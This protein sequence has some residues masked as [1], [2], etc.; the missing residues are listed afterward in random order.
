MADIPSS[1]GTVPAA[2]DIP[3]TTPATT[4][5]AAPSA[6]PAESRR[7]LALHLLWSFL[8][9]VALL[10]MIIAAALIIWQDNVGSIDQEGRNALLS[11]DSVIVFE[12]T[13]G[14]ATP[15]ASRVVEG[16]ELGTAISR[17]IADLV[18]S[19]EST[20]PVSLNTLD[21]GTTA[22]TV[23]YTVQYRLLDGTVIDV[24]YVPA[25]NSLFVLRRRNA[26]SHREVLTRKTPGKD[27]IQIFTLLFPP[28]K[29]DETERI[30]L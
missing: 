17:R 4:E 10:G 9:T 5:T 1:C 7:Q 6:A 29:V 2:T 3:A 12:L 8:G 26:E 16:R 14:T 11:P 27:L 25:N 22:F 21:P 30:Q 13:A 20:P 23:T 24:E 15:D 28:E 18:I 19:D